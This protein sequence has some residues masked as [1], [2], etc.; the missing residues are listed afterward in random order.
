MTFYIACFFLVS[1]NSSK[2][3]ENR[4]AFRYNESKGITT[5]DPA[6]ARREN[7]IRP[8]SQLFNGLLEMDDSLKIKPSV[9]KSWEIS[10]DGTGYTFHL[11][12]DLYFH[13]HRLFPGGKGRKVNANDFVYSFNRILDPKIASP[14]L[15]IFSQVDTFQ[16]NGFRALNDSTFFIK[17][18]RPF[19]SF[20]GLLTMPYCYVV[21]FEI[22]DHYGRDFRNNPVGTGPF[23]LKIWREGE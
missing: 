8:I 13:N 7:E 5:L 14:G 9:A 21:P 3:E 1:C 15:W 12:N 11:R 23:M 19:A 20:L 22:A 10:D 17:L 16:R 18:V 6:F 2:K 4:K